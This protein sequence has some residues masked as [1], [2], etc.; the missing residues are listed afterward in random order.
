MN[1]EDIKQWMSDPYRMNK[2]S[3]QALKSLL[4]EYPCFTTVR[5]LYLKSLLN[6]NDLNFSSELIRTAISV[7]DRRR[8]YYFVEGKKVPAYKV[9]PSSG[10]LETGGFSL[11]DRYLKNSTPNGETDG[12]FSESSR[13]A[14]EPNLELIVS[15]EPN[16]VMPPACAE[17]VDTFQDAQQATEKKT[18]STVGHEGLLLDYSKYLTQQTE[19]DL[20]SVPMQ[21]Q[22]LI[23]RFLAGSKYQ[24]PA[25][26][27]VLG[28]QEQFRSRLE[29]SLED[30]SYIL[31][32][33]D[34]NLPE[35]SFTETLARIYLKQK[36]Y[37][38]AIEIFKSLSL[39]YPEK[40]IYFA[41]QI[42]FL[43][44]LIENLKK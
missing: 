20:P 9:Q 11:I 44:K 42:R 21:G 2:E 36:R 13:A 26:K 4:V 18:L 19:I 32:T 43:E 30:V 29:S 22:D 31:D 40:N 41:D 3:M 34:F 23:D 16:L 15:D 24:D 25:I 38:R 1:V 35:D 39:K 37:D 17:S 28:E 8:L 6:L 12:S 33:P 7:P 14:F 10:L 5:I 27:P